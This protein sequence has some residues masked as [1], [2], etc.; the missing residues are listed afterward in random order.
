[1]KF[2]GEFE[3]D[4]SQEKSLGDLELTSNKESSSELIQFWIYKGDKLTIIHSA[5]ISFLEQ[6]NFRIIKSK[7][8]K[9]TA[10]VRE[11]KGRINECR[12]ADVIKCIQKFLKKGWLHDVYEQFV[13]GI[14]TYINAKKLT[15]LQEIEAFDDRD[16]KNS[17]FFYFDNIVSEVTAKGIEK[18]GYDE[19]NKKIWE[20]RII[21]WEYESPKSESIGQFER[22][23][24]RLAKD[25]SRRI[26]AL[27]S[28]LGYLLHRNKHIGETV[29]I[30]FY[31][32]N[33][34]NN[35]ANGGTGKSLLSR[36]LNYCRELV[37]HDGKKLKKDSVFI[38]QRVGL[39]TDIILYDDMAKNTSLDFFFSELTSG[40][41]VEKKYQDAFYID[42]EDSPKY[43]LTSNHIIQGDNASS[44]LRRR[45][46]YEV[47]NHYSNEFTP[48]DEFG[49]RFFEKNW[50]ADEWNKFY[51]FMMDCVQVY[52]DKGLIEAEPLNLKSAK[53]LTKCNENLLEF[54]DAYLE[55]N[56]R[57]D[58]RI[59]QEKYQTFFPKD[60]MS[61]HK[62]TKCLKKY[63][64]QHNYTIDLWPS[65]GK[66]YYFIK[67]ED[68]EKE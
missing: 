45:Y 55:L 20:S 56:N 59:L 29:A 57:S 30:I 35:K 36:A 32:E 68:H 24:Q 3:K 4:N 48:E 46:E 65:G 2:K 15:L 50:P 64:N 13:K 38:N 9:G 33:M 61:R 17:S 22:F 53:I 16:K 39:T 8:G 23:V 11:Q 62:F 40:I 34:V 52:L 1:M 27:Q 25:D 63:C 19:L 41:Q 54:F 58:R 37:H 49:N 26:I 60:K 44:D 14:G 28:A 66:Y 47:A 31:D 10:L 12:E 42:F 7:N 51:K 6:N 5:I 21:S 18:F 67:T 43:I